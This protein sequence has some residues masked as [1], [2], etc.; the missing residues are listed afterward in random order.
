MG[1]A[2]EARAP[3]DITAFEAVA[4]PPYSQVTERRAPEGEP[5][6]VARQRPDPRR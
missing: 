6:R 4:R 5:R 1:G 3:G 2:I